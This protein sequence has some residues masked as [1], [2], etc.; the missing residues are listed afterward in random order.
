MSLIAI[1]L[2]EEDRRLTILAPLLIV[3]YKQFIDAVLLKSIIDVYSTKDLAWTHGERM[4]QSDKERQ[5]SQIATSWRL[6]L[7]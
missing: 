7:I 4:K 1:E 5:N 2:D 6:M 3:G